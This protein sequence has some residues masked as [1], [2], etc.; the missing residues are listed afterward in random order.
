LI[1][2]ITLLGGLLLLY[3]GAEWLVKGAA[4]LGRSIGVPSLVIGLT[5][6]AYGTSMPELVVSSIAAVGGQSS[7]ALGN[8]V[9][10]NIANIAFVLAMVAI[11]APLRIE[12]DSIR[13]E[14]AV[15]LATTLV[16]PLLLAAGGVG[17]VAGLILLAGAILFTV[18]AVRFTGPNVNRTAVLVEGDA[19]G[20]GAPRGKGR[21]G[22]AVIGLTG[23]VLLLVGGQLFVDGATGVAAR[24]GIS[25]RVIGLTVAAVGTSAPE[26]AASVVA[27]IR[28]HAGIALGNVVGSN[29]FNVLFVLGGAAAIAPVHA[30]LA[31]F[32]LDVVYLALLSGALAVLAR[33]HRTMRRWE[34]AALLI[35]YGIYL[36]LLFRG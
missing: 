2:T 28:G 31:A 3:I 18:F 9:G 8:V 32:R 29:I 27:A 1:P 26:L 35:S 20:A 34:G 16:I 11:I 7:V 23:L 15:L 19:E 36:L 13:R 5:A 4:G 33:K 17:R 21:A 25:D 10:S 30:T 6:V 14:L 12:G 24:F 22:L